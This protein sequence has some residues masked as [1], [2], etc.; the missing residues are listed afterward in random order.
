MYAL[1]MVLLYYLCNNI[2][3]TVHTPVRASEIKCISKGNQRS[4]GRHGLG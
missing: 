4:G 3:L 1:H 2:S